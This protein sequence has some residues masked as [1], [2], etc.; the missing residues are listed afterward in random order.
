MALLPGVA[1]RRAV[2]PAGVGSRPAGVA[3]ANWGDRMPAEDGHNDL[4]TRYQRY[5]STI[6][7]QVHQRPAPGGGQSRQ[8]RRLAVIGVIGALLVGVFSGMAIQTSRAGRTTGVTRTVPASQD[9]QQAIDQAD[10]SLG[11]AVKVEEALAEHTEYMNELMQGKI[12]SATAMRK[13]MPSLISGAS[14]S[15][16][17]DAALRSYRRV[18][19]SC[20][21]TTNP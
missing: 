19:V 18:V 21:L 12:D 8:R 13:G 17:F 1:G 9:C 7:A 14:A 15:E 3:V 5:F 4:D 11:E 20:K 16:R 2:R 10:R 6:G